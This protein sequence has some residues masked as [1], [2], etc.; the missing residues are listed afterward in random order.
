MIRLI[1][2]LE[3]K[4]F[5]SCD[6]LIF[7]SK[8]MANRAINDYGLDSGKILVFYPFTTIEKRKTTDNALGHLFPSGFKHIVYS[9]AVGEK[10]NPHKLVKFF[11]RI[12][13][14]RNDIIC[15][16]FSRGPLFDE[17]QKQN[18]KEFDRILFH[19]LVSEENLYELYLRSDIQVIPQKN[20]TSEGAIPSKLPNIISAGTPIFSISD[21]GS[22]LSQIVNESGIGYCADSWDIDNLVSELNDFLEVTKKNSHHERQLMVRDYVNKSFGIHQLV[23]TIMENNGGDRRSPR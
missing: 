17:L 20:G 14:D 19:D 2:F 21:P 8:S 5:A 7:L 22:E 10:Q 9:G 16:L 6:K 15:H 13:T 1:R 18:Y 4:S 23:D 11:Q 12:V 3:K